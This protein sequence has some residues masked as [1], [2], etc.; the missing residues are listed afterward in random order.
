MSWGSEARR[1]REEAGWSRPQLA[2]LSGVSKNAIYNFENDRLANGI[3]LYIAVALADVLGL[4]LDEYIGRTPPEPT[5]LK[6]TKG[7][8]VYE[9]PW[10]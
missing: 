1:H 10:K 9:Y 6:L 2:E 5:K 3:S 4:S 8:E 7:E